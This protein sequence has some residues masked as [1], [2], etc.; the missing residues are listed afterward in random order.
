LA[1]P[2]KG[3]ACTMVIR[4]ILILKFPSLVLTAGSIGTLLVE[5]AEKSRSV[6]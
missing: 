1:L 2:Q 4:P 5:G 6:F 3:L